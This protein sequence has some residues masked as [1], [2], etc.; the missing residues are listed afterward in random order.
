M[1]DTP[2]R[3]SRRR[4]C[5]AALSIVTVFVLVTALW[6]ARP[7]AAQ[8]A[9]P[10]G[11][12]QQG[13][14]APVFRPG[15]CPSEIDLPDGFVA[16]DTARCGTVEVPQSRGRSDL[17]PLTLPV[18]VFTS[19]SA[20]PGATP[21]IYLAGGPGG[22]GLEEVTLAF[23]DSPLGQ[24]LVRDRPVIAFDQRGTGLSQPS[25]DC[26]ML[27][28]VPTDAGLM[29]SA[30]P[31]ALELIRACRAALERRG[32]NLASINTTETSHD[33]RD[34][35]LALGYQRAL[36]MGTSYGTTGTLY[37]M[38]NHPEV[39]E[40]AIL[41]GVAPPQ[42]LDGYEDAVMELEARR[43]FERY[44]RDCDRDPVC[45]VE[46]PDLRRRFAELEARA[47][48]RLVLRFDEDDEPVTISFGLL[49]TLF[50]DLIREPSL[51]GQIP[52]FVEETLEG[53]P[54]RLIE[55]LGFVLVLAAIGELPDLDPSELPD[56]AEDA[57]RAVYDAV[58][59]SDFPPGTP[60]GGRPVCDAWG[61]PFQG[62]HVSA[63]VVSSI[64]TL[65]LSGD[66]DY[67]TPPFWAMET[68]RR[69]E[70]SY[71]Y[72]LPAAGHVV[73]YSQHSACVAVLVLSFIADP[74]QRPADDCVDRLEG[75]RFLPRP[76]SPVT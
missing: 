73:T 6:P 70:N 68:A 34:I 42:W 12:V 39:V 1:S 33:V 30:P 19:P 45:S 37:T 15:A 27:P 35:I 52:L 23:L 36:V 41:D 21:L 18:I 46:F 38:R 40:A 29:R 62:P 3:Y 58:L 60:D 8:A 72:V 10:A 13:A 67:Q 76:V 59:C 55:E 32:V 65:L 75:P 51:A 28:M 49:A 48:E 69:L 57:H 63:P 25:L 44:L 64:P 11:A 7:A 16:G 56:Q 31:P 17:V 22:S 71:S 4:T 50:S 54:E 2:A 74:T 66:Y 43:A 24:T 53:N 26:P 47:E 61:V 5:R 9:P 20:S 14:V